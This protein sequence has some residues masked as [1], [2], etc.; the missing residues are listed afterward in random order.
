[1]PSSSIVSLARRFACALLSATAILGLAAVSDAPARARNTNIDYRHGIGGVNIGMRRK[2]VGKFL[3]RP[4]HD[5]EQE[6]QDAGAGIYLARYT[7][8]EL[9]VFYVTARGRAPGGRGDK[10]VG[11]ST[12][13]S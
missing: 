3:G 5:K 10:V 12:F 8:E 2:T 9:G 1:M 11:V 13:S 7:D 4:Q 6:L